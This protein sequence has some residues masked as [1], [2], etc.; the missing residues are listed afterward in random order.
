MKQEMTMS[1]MRLSDHDKFYGAM[2]GGQRKRGE[3]RGQPAGLVLSRIGRP[4]APP[5]VPGGK[6]VRPPGLVNMRGCLIGMIVRSI[7][8]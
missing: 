2:P 8:E 7:G 3:G 1:K 5:P 6:R 4:Y